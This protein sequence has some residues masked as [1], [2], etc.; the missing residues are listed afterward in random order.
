[1]RLVCL[2]RGSVHGSS[3]S[4]FVQFSNGHF[5]KR[6]FLAVVVVASTPS[7]KPNLRKSPEKHPN[8]PK[9]ALSDVV[10][11]AAMILG[12]EIDIR[13]LESTYPPVKET[14]R[15]PVSAS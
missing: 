12:H 11:A 15:K 5:L 13:I 8:H 1:V 14:L 4:H 2:G 9:L 7:P 3:I 6:I 10:R